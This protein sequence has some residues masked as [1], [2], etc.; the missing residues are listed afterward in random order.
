M[1]GDA[2][3]VIGGGWAGCAAAVELAR[4]GV[5]VTLFETAPVLGGRARR[6]LRAGLPLDNGQHLLLG[7]YAQ[8]CALL[9]LVHGEAAAREVFTRHPLTI[10]PLSPLQAGALTLIRGRTEGTLGLLTGLLGARGLTWRERIANIAWMR[11]LKRTQFVRAPYETV[12]HML[13]PLPPRV[14]KGLVGTAVPGGAQHAAGRC[15]R[16]DLRQRAEGRVRGAARRLRLPAAGDRPVGDVSR[17][18]RA[19]RRDPGRNRTHL[20]A[21]ARD[22]RCT[23]PSD[24]AR[25][26]AAARFPR[27][28]RRGRSASG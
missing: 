22:P 7:A 25:R 13:A 10:M 6:V 9:D 3:A 23:P 1:S 20:G 2:V 8:T 24:S 12:A 14:A 17:S 4:A 27:R 16:A 28:H 18:R 21:G 19:L 26:Y 15:V 5:P 11:K